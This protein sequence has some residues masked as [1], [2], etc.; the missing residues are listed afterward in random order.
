MADRGRPAAIPILPHNLN[1]KENCPPPRQPRPPNPARDAAVVP[2]IVSPIDEKTISIPEDPEIDIFTVSPVAILKMLCGSLEALVLLTGDA[3]PTPPIILPRT[4]RMEELQLETQSAPKKSDIDLVEQE[5]FHDSPSAIASDDIEGTAFRRTP[6]GSPES[7]ASHPP[8]IIGAN[9]ESEAVQQSTIARKFYS[10]RPPPIPLEEYLLRLH[11]YCPMSTAVFL[12]ASLYIHRMT[13]VERL[14]PLTSRNVHRLLLA[15]LRVAMKAL[16]DLSYPHS[17]FAK[18]GGV[19]ELELGRL[20][21]SFCFMANFEL[22]VSEEM[23]M[24]QATSLRIASLDKSPISLQPQLPPRKGK[25]L[26]V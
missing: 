3:P 6:I 8:T 16:E 25:H 11:R 13:V 2:E 20:E 4:F 7:R 15:A 10:R 5:K 9:A 22:K 14:L 19:T 17:R 12:A 21:V 23:L 18:V 24:E 1:A 26:K